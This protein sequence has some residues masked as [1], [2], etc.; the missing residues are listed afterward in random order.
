MGQ[1]EVFELINIISLNNLDLVIH[2]P[3]FCGDGGG[4]GGYCGLYVDN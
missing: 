2:C 4:G 1:K 3:L